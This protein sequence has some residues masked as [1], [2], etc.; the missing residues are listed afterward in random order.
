MAGLVEVT[1]NGLGQPMPAVESGAILILLQGGKTRIVAAELLPPDDFGPSLIH[2][3]NEQDL[4]ADALE[5]LR[6]HRPDAFHGGR[7]FTFVCPSELAARAR[8]P[9]VPAGT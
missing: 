6:A 9:D 7:A 5:L 1:F 4:V 3:L 8:F 2:A